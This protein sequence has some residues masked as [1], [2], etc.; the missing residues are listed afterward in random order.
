MVA[1]IIKNDIHYEKKTTSNQ[2]PGIHT[3]THIYNIHNIILLSIN[4][5]IP[6]NS[7]VVALCY[8]YRCRRRVIA[9]FVQG[10]A[11]GTADVDGDDDPRDGRS[12]LVSRSPLPAVTYPYAGRRYA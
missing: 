6:L 11:R 10:L 8:Y 9:R 1:S 3:H 4:Y 2:L 7:D 12:E 5:N